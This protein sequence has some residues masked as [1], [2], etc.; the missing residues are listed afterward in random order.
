MQ[1]EDFLTIFESYDV[2]GIQTV[3][4][5]YLEQAYQVVGVEDAKEVLNDRYPQFHSGQNR[6]ESLSCLCS[7]RRA[8]ALWLKLCPPKL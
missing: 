6:Q 8:Q 5:A 4:V 2:L 7:A 3:P 1:Q